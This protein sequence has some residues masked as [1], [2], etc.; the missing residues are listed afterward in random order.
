MEI[1]NWSLYERVPVYIKIYDPIFG[2]DIGKPYHINN[3]IFMPN[4]R[5]NG[6]ARVESYNYFDSTKFLQDRNKYLEY[7]D[8]VAESSCVTDNLYIIDIHIPNQNLDTNFSQRNKSV[9]LYLLDNYGIA[10]LRKTIY[11]GCQTSRFDIKE[12]SIDRE[13]IH[14]ICIEQPKKGEKH[15]EPLRPEQIKFIQKNKLIKLVDCDY[16]KSYISIDVMKQ[17]LQNET[18]VRDF[19]NKIKICKIE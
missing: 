1:Q 6:I 15:I 18:V 9:I 4:K 10:H 8:P 5:K 7:N 19:M 13:I 17:I 12:P 16:K 3:I 2:Y 11:T 14:T